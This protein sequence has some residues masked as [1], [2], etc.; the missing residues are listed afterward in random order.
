MSG[1]TRAVAGRGRGRKSGAKRQLPKTLAV[2]EGDPSEDDVVFVAVRHQH[3]LHPR[4][5]L[6]C[7]EVLGLQR[8][9]DLQ[10][11]RTAYRQRALEAHPDRPRGSQTA[12]LSIAE[13]FE[14]LSDR[15]AREVYDRELIISDSPDG[16]GA[17]RNCGA[18]SA[19]SSSKTSK[20]SPAAGTCPLK[21][22][23]ALVSMS[24]SDW[25]RHVSGL[26]SQVLEDARRHLS[27]GIDGLNGAGQ[28][29]ARSGSRC[30]LLLASKLR[31]QGTPDSVADNVLKSV[32]KGMHLYCSSGRYW[33]AQI[34]VGGLTI[35][36]QLTKCTGTAAD[37]HI[38][39]L[40][41]KELLLLHGK[42]DE[43]CFDVYFR[44]ARAQASAQNIDPYGDQ[45]LYFFVKTFPVGSG[46]SNNKHFCVRTPTVKDLDTALAHRR[47]VLE[48]LERGSARRTVQSRISRLR[49]EVKVA[50]KIWKDRCA[51]VE[52]QLAGYILRELEQRKRTNEPGAPKRRRLQGKQS[53]ALMHFRLPWLNRFAAKNGMNRH[54]LVTKLKS[55]QDSVER[56]AHWQDCVQR[57]LQ[58]GLED[59]DCGHL[60]LLN[61]IDREHCS[62]H[63][64][65]GIACGPSPSPTNGVDEFW[66]S[67]GAASLRKDLHPEAVSP[68]YE[69]L[70]EY[71]EI[72]ESVDTP[73]PAAVAPEA[74]MQES[75]RTKPNDHL[76]HEVGV[77]WSDRVVTAGVSSSS[78]GAAKSSASVARASKAAAEI[79]QP[80]VED[81]ENED[82]DRSWAWTSELFPGFQELQRHR[83]AR[84]RQN[85]V[86]TPGPVIMEVDSD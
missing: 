79:P 25:G 3:S 57:A 60:A 6:R 42:K 49:T 70:K 41:Y 28:T 29:D 1:Q 31:Q 65:H 66:G 4:K 20:A 53:Q 47:V 48:M 73:L 59:L 43:Q 78:S 18:G 81:V 69:E 58:R 74:A 19:T 7:Y 9:A 77:P 51:K 86:R 33:F 37:G 76:R 67:L 30:P 71:E 13:A 56:S 16:L 44:Q 64:M 39:L 50:Q 61:G 24:M 8:G 72:K 5:E 14:T 63:R 52:Q 82:H 80:H 84:Q 62:S 40:A 17:A 26:S 10:E 45:F 22:S 75:C 11:V 12:F 83:A 27:G 2:Y 36:S 46:A 21:V 15:S 68:T 54:E 32:A 85:V 38:A 35:R 55:L 34:C 23:Q